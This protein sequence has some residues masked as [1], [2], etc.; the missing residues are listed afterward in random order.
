MRLKGTTGNLM[1]SASLLPAT[2]D[3][4]A[5]G[6]TTLSFSDLF[7]ASGAVI[8][9]NNGNAVVT[10]SSGILNV[11]TGDL[12]VT[13]AGTHATSVAT[14]DGTQTL[15]NKSIVATQL[16]GTAYT[17]AV[18]NTNATAAYTLINYRNDVIANYDGTFTWNSTAPTTIVS[19]KYVF[20]RIGNMVILTISVLY[21]TP[22]ATNTTCIVTFPSGVPSPAVFANSGDAASEYMYPIS[23]GRVEANQTANPSA[24]RGG[25]RRNAGDSA[26]EILLIF[27]STSALQLQVTVI[28]FTA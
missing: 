2:N 27:G 14:L 7:L 26:F 3:G 18:N 8:N 16:T 25:I 6:S 4:A 15:T 24:I 19:Q 28:Y 13:T 23:G 1:L 12:R 11:T 5:L 10:H 22:G 20:S 17:M 9:F 21:T